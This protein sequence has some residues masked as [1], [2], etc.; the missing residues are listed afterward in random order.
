MPVTADYFQGRPIVDA[1]EDLTITV[2]GRDFKKALRR[3]PTACVL[4]AAVDHKNEIIEGHI[5]AQ[6]VYLRTKAAP[7]NWTRYFLS[8]KDQ[9]KIR[10][11]DSGELHVDAIASWLE[12]IPMEITFLK[13]PAYYNMGYM[14]GKSGTNRRGSN[15]RKTDEVRD[16]IKTRSR[17]LRHLRWP[18]PE[19]VDSE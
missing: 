17:P 14:R 7:D 5:G 4:A 15:K 2:T 13:P 16:N 8:K 1:T 10:Y 12:K 3:D 11:F 6:V 19:V 18:E 9:R